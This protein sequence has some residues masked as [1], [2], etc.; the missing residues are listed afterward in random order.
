MKLLD[1]RLPRLPLRRNAIDRFHAIE[2]RARCKPDTG[3]LLK[4]H[5]VLLAECEARRMRETQE[6][7]S[8]HI[9]RKTAFSSDRILEGNDRPSQVLLGKIER[10]IGVTIV[11]RRIGAIDAQSNVQQAI[12]DGLASVADGNPF[13]QHR[14]AV[15]PAINDSRRDGRIGR[16]Q[17]EH[18]LSAVLDGSSRP[19][20]HR[21][22]RREER[23]AWKPDI[24]FDLRTA[25]QTQRSA[26]QLI[27]P[28]NRTQF[29]RGGQNKLERRRA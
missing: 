21:E 12:P 26:A 20:F 7:L 18:R 19:L 6:E 10:I 22:F 4:N 27:L 16:G 24:E 28:R 8:L 15:G 23:P 13:V 5:R 1:E 17:I 14:L 9:R 3:Q 29:S 2:T 11:E 25:A